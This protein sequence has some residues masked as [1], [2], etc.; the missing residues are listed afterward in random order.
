[1]PVFVLRPRKRKRQ[2]FQVL[3]LPIGKPARAHAGHVRQRD[4][5][6]GEFRGVRLGA[7]Q[8]RDAGEDRRRRGAVQLLEHHGLGE[9]AKRAVGIIHRGSHIL[10]LVKSRQNAGFVNNRA[11]NRVGAGQIRQRVVHVLDVA[12]GNSRFRDQPYAGH[13]EFHHGRI[14]FGSRPSH[15]GF[16]GGHRRRNGLR[17]G[18]GT[19]AP[20]GPRTFRHF[21]SQ[22]RPKTKR[23]PKSQPRG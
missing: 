9:R 20:K 5:F 8:F 22:G 2:A 23:S 21:L 17:R 7:D 13:G 11:E 16:R 15:R 18:W 12:E 10:A 6:G 14:G 1:M 4:A 3:Q 19:L